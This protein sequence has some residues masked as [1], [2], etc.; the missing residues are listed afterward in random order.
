MDFVELAVLVVGFS[1]VC[2]FIVLLTRQLKGWALDGLNNLNSRMV[3]Q[4]LLSKIT[5]EELHSLRKEFDETLARKEAYWL[6]KEDEFSKQEVILNFM[7]E[8]K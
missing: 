2:G 6:A 7:E 4:E 8:R 5:A 3:E 1:L